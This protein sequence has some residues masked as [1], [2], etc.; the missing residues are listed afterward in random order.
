MS[1]AYI[2]TA[3]GTIYRPGAV[4][5]GVQTHARMSDDAW[6]A[7]GCVPYVAPPPEPPSPPDPLA[8]PMSKLSLR[9]ALRALGLE[10]ALDAVLAADATAARDWAD[11]QTLRLDDP[12]LA[13][14]M[15]MFVAQ[16]GMTDED[17]AA[18][19]AEAVQSV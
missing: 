12:M 18:L 14:M 11:A 1:T 17:V 10:E 4:V 5:A 15:P 16:A 2:H 13:A 8:Q 3:T 19:V 9:R 6:A 7:L